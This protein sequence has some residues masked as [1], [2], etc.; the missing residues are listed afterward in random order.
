MF[1]T[2]A[3]QLL[4]ESHC[5]P[6]LCMASVESSMNRASMYICATASSTAAMI[7][8]QSASVLSVVVTTTMFA[9]GKLEAIGVFILPFGSLGA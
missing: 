7:A 5:I 9:P 3:P 2:D 1:L 8:S 4:S 6:S